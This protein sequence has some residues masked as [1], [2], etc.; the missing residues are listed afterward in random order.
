MCAT[1]RLVN[2]K[3]GQP[4]AFEILL[5]APHD[6]RIALPYVQAL[7]QV[8]GSRQRVKTLDMPQYIERRVQFD[9]DMIRD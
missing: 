3:T 1:E 7:K 8:R 2:G 6:E 4:F 9:F 5:K